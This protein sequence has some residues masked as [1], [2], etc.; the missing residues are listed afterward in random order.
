MI[1]RGNYVY[2]RVSGPT[3]R[4]DIT[5]KDGAG[6]AARALPHGLIGQVTWAD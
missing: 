2:D 1:V 4:L 5:F 3:H 6:A